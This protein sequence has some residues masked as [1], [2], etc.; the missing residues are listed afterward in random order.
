MEWR[1]PPYYANVHT[2]RTKI[3]NI[4]EKDTTSETDLSNDL[5]SFDNDMKQVDRKHNE[6]LNQTPDITM[7]KKAR[8]IN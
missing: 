5:V 4:L 7:I 3:P 6:E 1:R 8:E 2:N